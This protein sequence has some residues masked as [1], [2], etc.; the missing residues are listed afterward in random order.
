M[1]FM[2]NEDRFI[3]SCANVGEADVRQKLNAGR[4]SER[5]A[6]WAATWLDQVESGKS[7][8]TRA[9]ET[10]RLR[11]SIRPNGHSAATVGALLVVLL[12]VGAV[13]FVMFG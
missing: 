12:L 2:T 1:Q 11:N 7:D 6:L 4:Y 8:A 5:R 9:E 3:A 10:S 13:L